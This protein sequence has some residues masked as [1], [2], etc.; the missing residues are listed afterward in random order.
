MFYFFAYT[1]Y[2]VY[3][4]ISIPYIAYHLYCHTLYIVCYLYAV[5]VYILSVLLTNIFILYVLLY[6]YY[7]TTV[8]LQIVISVLFIR[9]FLYFLYYI[10]RWF[11]TCSRYF[12]LFIFVIFT[13]FQC[14]L[15]LIFYCLHYIRGKRFLDYF[16]FIIYLQFYLLTIPVNGCMIKAHQTTRTPNKVQGKPQ[17]NGKRG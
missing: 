14:F 9:L 1:L 7:V 16:S 17:A 15:A 11:F 3:C 12:L 5:S 4:T 10:F 2:A 13:F 8:S 6:L